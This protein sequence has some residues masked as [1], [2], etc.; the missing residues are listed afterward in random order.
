MRAAIYNAL[1]GFSTGGKLLDP[2]SNCQTG[3]CTWDPFITLGVCGG[4]INIT[5]LLQGT[6]TEDYVYWSLP[7]QYNDVGTI[8]WLNHQTHPYS[9][10]N[11]T[12][13]QDWGWGPPPKASFL[14]FGL[15]QNSLFNQTEAIARD[16]SLRYCLHEV[17]AKISSGQLTENTIEVEG[18]WQSNLDVTDMLLTPNKSDCNHTSFLVSDWASSAL[19]HTM[20][21]LINGTAT[22]SPDGV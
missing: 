6:H 14:H 12:S 2:P 16:C 15:V 1:L 10:V 21:S 19:Y 20:L 9:T 13:L 8:G 7:A 3:N 22:S 4:C 11:I 17:E 5:H 18:S